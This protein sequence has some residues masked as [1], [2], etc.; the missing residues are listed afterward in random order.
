MVNKTRKQQKGKDWRS[1]GENGD[2]KGIFCPKMGTMK[3]INGRDLVDTEE[4]EKRWKNTW[5]NCIRKIE[6][7]RTAAMVCSATQ[8]QTF[9]GAKSSG[10]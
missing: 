5:K 6:M 3:D 1:L 4:I 2:I 8:S 7:N 9:W 10:P